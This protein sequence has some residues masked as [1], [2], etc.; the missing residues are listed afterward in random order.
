MKLKEIFIDNIYSFY[1]FTITLEDSLNLIVGTNGV[2]K[3]NFIDL[4]HLVLNGEISKLNKLIGNKR[5]AKIQIKIELSEQEIE[6]LTNLCIIN[7]IITNYKK[8]IK[9]LLEDK[10]SNDKQIEKITTE[11]KSNLKFLIIEYKFNL[12]SMKIKYYDSKKMNLQDY[13][14][15]YRSKLND[16]YNGNMQIENSIIEELIE[17]EL[18]NCIN[19]YFKYCPKNIT[20]CISNIVPQFYGTF[21]EQMKQK[22]KLICGSEEN[23]KSKIFELKNCGSKKFKEMR[24]IFENITGKKFNIRCDPEDNYYVY[25][26]K[27]KKDEF[28][29]S[30]GESELISFLG[31]YISGNNK[32]ILIDEPCV[33]LSYQNKNNFRKY[34]LENNNKNH[35]LV[36]VTHDPYLIGMRTCYGIHRFGINKEITWNK[37]LNNVDY[38]WMKKHLFEHKEILFSKKCLLIE[39]YHDSRFFTEFLKI[40]DQQDYTIIIMNGGDSQLYKVLNYFNV[41][42]KIILDADKLLDGKKG[43]CKI[44]ISKCWNIYKRHGK[45]KNIIHEMLEC[46][47]KDNSLKL[48]QIK[49]IVSSNYYKKYIQY[50]FDYLDNR[51]D[52]NGM[53]SLFNEL[54]A[55]C[56]ETEFIEDGK[57]KKQLI[58]AIDKNHENIAKIH[59]K[60]LI[61]YLS[62]K[63]SEND[64]D[65]KNLDK[66][67]KTLSG[68][69][70]SHKIKLTEYGLLGDNGINT[71]EIYKSQ[72]ENILFL[73]PEIWD[74]EGLWE[75]ISDSK[76]YNNK[77]KWHCIGN[78]DIYEK[79]NESI[80]YGHNFKIKELNTIL[81]FLKSS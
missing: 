56:K 48:K 36:I 34:V 27:G 46:E 12:Y 26:I 33:Y 69:K 62:G 74:L 17:N 77:K 51:C 61:K 14:I 67:I 18:I 79:I 73:H 5:N 59:T 70:E 7:I 22:V 76:I 65:T 45:D 6:Q 64:S 40:T 19:T 35:Q 29:C 38:D 52:C 13:F 4:V 55:K 24:Q 30:R 32:I 47:E 58:Q 80:D 53:K 44:S 78:L 63:R 23:I 42:Y 15:H 11:L 2:G 3:S 31:N 50:V 57:I 41:C 10:L 60:T 39:G 25:K 66:M 8:Y 16:N 43:N 81:K 1:D 49:R 75:K 37:S 71:F 54:T 21:G 28:N 72:C 68:S 9:L 20:S